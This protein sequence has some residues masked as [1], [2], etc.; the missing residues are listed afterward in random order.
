V[1]TIT[2]RYIPYV[3]SLYDQIKDAHRL[4]LSPT[5]RTGR[6]IGVRLGI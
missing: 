3:F 4:R 6:G 5:G 2:V 1:I